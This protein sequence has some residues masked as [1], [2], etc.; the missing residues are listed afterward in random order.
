MIFSRDKALVGTSV[1]GV[2]FR[3]ARAVDC[4]SVE[5]GDIPVGLFSGTGSSTFSIYASTERISASETSWVQPTI[6]VFLNPFAF[7]VL[8]VLMNLLLKIT[9]SSSG[10]ILL[11]CM[12]SCTFYICT[13]YTYKF[14]KVA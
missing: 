6:L 9:Q 1:G 2:I 7:S 8:A 12:I 14:F 5:G 3:H 11:V 10:V 4:T 13:S